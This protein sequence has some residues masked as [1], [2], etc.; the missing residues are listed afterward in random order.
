MKVV[1]LVLVELYGIV[2][3]IWLWHFPFLSVVVAVIW[4]RRCEYQGYTNFTLELDSTIIT[5]KLNNNL[6]T[7]MKLK[8][9]VD[10]IKSIK[11][12]IGIQVT[13][14]F[15]EGNQ[16]ADWLAKLAST[17]T[18]ILIT[19]SLSH[20]PRQA[21]GCIQLDKWMMPSLRCKYDKSNFFVS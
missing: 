13:H 15:R 3:A 6:V 1:R 14:C 12:R 17:S 2:E 11:N 9:V 8:Q 16:V 21:R 19:Q 10:N 7:N 18:Q 4:Q 5:N 20:L